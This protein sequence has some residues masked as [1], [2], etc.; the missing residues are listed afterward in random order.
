MAQIEKI[1][2]HNDDAERSVLGSILLDKEVFFKVSEFISA[3]DFYEPAHKEIY[4]AMFSLYQD[5]SP[6][7]IVTVCERLQRRKSLEQCG[8]RSFVSEL[9][10]EIA[11]TANAVQYAHIIQ[12]KSVLRQLIQ[13]GSGIVEN[14]FAQKQDCGQI[15][16]MAEQS[17]FD[18]AKDR[19]TKDY[20]PIQKVLDQN[21]ERMEEAEKRK[22]EI[23]GLS[24]GFTDLDRMLLGLQKSDLIIIAA[25][26][27]MGKTAFSLNIAQNAALNLK[28]RVAFFS[29]EMSDLA[30]GDRL[31]AIESRVDSKKFRIGQ[32]NS[33]DWDSVNRAIK[34]YA[35]ADLLI[36]A[37]P[38]ISVMELRNKCRRMNSEKPLD[39]I[40]I[41][42]LQIM[43]LGE[44][45]ESRVN[46]V[47]AMTRYLKQLAREMECPVV[48][49]SQLSRSA[50]QR[51]DS[52]NRPRLDDLRDSG[53]IEQDADVVMFLHNEDYYNRTNPGYQP[54]G[55]CEVIVSKQRQGEVGTVYLSWMPRFQKFAN[56]RREDKR[57]PLPTSSAASSLPA[58]MDDNGFSMADFT[59]AEEDA[60]QAFQPDMFEASSEEFEKVEF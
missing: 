44:R 2:P 25:R 10:A 1:P 14:A 30:L 23:P 8:G 59:A 24:T 47:S 52:D 18:I 26:P 7:D 27:S 53:S 15:L 5:N 51:K 3:D 43:T 48:V 32:M 57:Q 49:L 60:E 40:I 56:N 50:V 37:T 33:D 35:D 41:D 4:N 28:K 58:N 46:E 34:R 38:G 12:E 13:A 19:Q 22:G 31:L 20:V 9:A 39:L 54:K 45:A 29:V 42:Y 55:I 36:D 16:D 17:I 21:V 11:T 6:I